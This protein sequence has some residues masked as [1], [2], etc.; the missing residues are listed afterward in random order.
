MT[1]SF[2]DL[3]TATWPQRQGRAKLVAGAAAASWRTA[4]EW[5]QRRCVPSADVLLRMAQRDDA[6]RAELVRLLT[7]NRGTHE[8]MGSLAA[9]D[10]EHRA[11]RGCGAAGAAGSVVPGQGGAG[12]PGDQAAGVGQGGRGRGS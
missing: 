9:A 6:L 4:Q 1:A 10:G 7:A 5:M 11:G 8:E 12:L 2:T 3:C